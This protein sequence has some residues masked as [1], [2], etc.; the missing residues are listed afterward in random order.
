MLTS[1]CKLHTIDAVTMRSN[2]RPCN[3]TYGSDLCCLANN[4]DSLYAVGSN[5]HI[6]LIDSRSFNIVS[7]INSKSPE[8]RIRSMSFNSEILTLTTGFGN[9]LFYDIRNSRYFHN[10]LSK[11]LVVL[12][13]SKGWNRPVNQE[14]Q[15][16]G[17]FSQPD[18]P[19]IYTH[20]YD[21][22]RTRLFTAGG[23]LQAMHVGN[24]CG[25]WS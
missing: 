11:E 18:L 22:G 17:Y 25:I 3:L 20:S 14:N 23:P 9:V 1:N 24:Y 19:A 6:Q 13:A 10:Q 12:K 15:N 7:T 4:E 5:S 8:C 2:Q 16:F 21:K